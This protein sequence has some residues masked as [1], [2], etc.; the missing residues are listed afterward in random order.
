MTH[1]LTPRRRGQER[2][3]ELLEVTL[4]I[5]A[6]TGGRGLTIEAIA[7]RAEVGKHTIYRRWP[8]ISELLVDTLGHVWA[9]DLDYRTTG[10]IREDLREQ[11][12]RSTKALTSPPLS[13]IYRAVI[14]EAQS[15]DSLRALIHE[16]FL[17]TVERSTLD[18]ILL[19]QLQ[20]ELRGDVDLTYPAEILCGTL[21]YRWL[22]TT[23]PVDE[24]AVDGL[25]DMFLAAY[26][27]EDSRHPTILE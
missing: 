11:F 16:R 25:I 15:S 14:A 8:S 2:T 7:R 19:A 26:G 21:Y 5:A 1:S 23:L 3:L 18:R 12:L 13:P 22:L 24:D 20:G 10:G 9:S 6:E 17:S 4:E 27:M